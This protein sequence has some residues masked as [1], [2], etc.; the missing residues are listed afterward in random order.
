MED[1]GREETAPLAMAVQAEK[2]D[3]ECMVIVSFL[4]IYNEEVY[5][6]LI[7]HKKN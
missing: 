5:D 7:D 2:P 4:E 6:L 3:R 1:H